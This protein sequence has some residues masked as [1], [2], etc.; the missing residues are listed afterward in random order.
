MRLILLGAPG[1]GKGTQATCIC[2]KYGIP[3][4]S[5]G[6]IFRQ[7]IKDKTELGLEAEGYI[8]KGLLVP[9]ELTLRIIKERLSHEDCS[10]GYL[11]DG[12]PRTISQAEAFKLYTEK[13][14]NSINIVLLIDLP[15]ELIIKRIT[16][17]RICSQCGK[18]YHIL[19][20][21]PKHERICDSCGCNLTQRKD[22]TAETVIQR[23]SIYEEQTKPLINYY[24]KQN[25]LSTIYGDGEVNIIF[26]NICK[27]I[28]NAK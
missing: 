24:L 10:N 27:I 9:D 3:H 5:T 26:R 17:R 6:D 21:P 13:S 4:I 8:H 22:D 25:L 11:L 20:S 7:N 1:A 2:T 16:G 14:N 12:F 18:S 28:D 19:F 23:L 15:S